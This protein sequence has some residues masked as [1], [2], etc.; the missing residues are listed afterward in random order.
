MKKCPPGV[1]CVENITLV[2]LCSITLI[3]IYLIHTKYTTNSTSQTTQEKQNIVVDVRQESSTPG[4][5]YDVLL[6]PY[7][8]PLR[9][10]RY[11]SHQYGLRGFPRTNIQTNIGA[12]NTSYRQVGILTPHRNAGDVETNKI[13]ALMG[14]PLFSNRDKWQF[15]TMTKNNIKLPIFRNGKSGTS[16]YGCDNIFNGDKIH[17]EGYNDAFKATIYDN[18]TMQYTPS[19]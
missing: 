8:P 17:V 6:N 7:T 19:I 2:I 11:S 12:V 5:G 14:R 9:D 4:L 13:L 18:D 10:D 3:V 15:Y 1:I 16:E